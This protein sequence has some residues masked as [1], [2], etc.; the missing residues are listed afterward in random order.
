MKPRWACAPFVILWITVLCPLVAAQRGSR[1]DSI[2]VAWL[3]CGV[4]DHGELDSV[5]ALGEHIIPVLAAYLRDGPTR[6]RR[7]AFS[8]RV[9][10]LDRLLRRYAQHHP[11]IGRV[12]AGSLTPGY[13]ANF[14]AAYRT[15]AAFALSCIRHP[16]ARDALLRIR[17]SGFRSDERHALR[18]A[19]AQRGRCSL[20][21]P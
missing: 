1:V 3:E 12:E 19:I 6:E 21:P 5:V 17:T 9:E 18:W 2:A 4:C 20:S 13:L 16:Q 14:T 7:L 11:E 8:K 15:R 10:A